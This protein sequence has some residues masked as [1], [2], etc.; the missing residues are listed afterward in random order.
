ME[1]NYLLIVQIHWVGTVGSIHYCTKLL[2]ISQD[3]GVTIASN[4]FT[5][6]NLY[7]H[8]SMFKP[9][10]VSTVVILFYRN[11]NLQLFSVVL[12]HRM[13]HVN[14]RKRRK[15]VVSP[16]HKQYRNPF[17][18]P[19][20][21]QIDGPFRACIHDDSSFLDRFQRCI[22]VASYYI[23]IIQS[24]PIEAHHKVCGL[25]FLPQIPTRYGTVWHHAQAV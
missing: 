20:Y 12:F 15:H 13:C 25:S 8:K 16:P 7:F 5:F 22:W 21:I 17:R 9:N 14:T 24:L 18:T 10:F 3:N 11:L 2:I 19:F 6:L 1:C 23:H 4:T